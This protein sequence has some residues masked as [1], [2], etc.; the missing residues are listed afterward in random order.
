MTSPTTRTNFWG[1]VRWWWQGR[2]WRR[3]QF[4]V[5]AVLAAACI[6][7]I[8]GMCLNTT[9]QELES[10]YLSE[11]KSAFQAKDYARALT[12]YERIVPNA[13]DRPDTLYRLA[14][15]AE[16]M[17]DH[18]RTA[19]IMRELAPDDRKGYPPAHYWRARQYL[20]LSPSPRVISAAELHLLRAL[21]GELE[22]R[23]T[24][25]G[26]LGQIYLNN[27]RLDEAEFHLTKAVASNPDFRMNLA[28]LF[29]ARGNTAKARQEA[30]VAA[31]KFRD[32]AR[33]DPANITARLAWANAVTF[34]EDF[35][36]ALDILKDGI[37]AT[38]DPTIYH[39]FIA[40][41]Y[42]AWYD[43]RKKEAGV[44]ISELIT[45]ID[46]GLSH[47][48]TNKDLLN[49]LIEQLRYGGPGADQGRKVL[50]ELLAKGGTAMGPVHF[51]LAID[52]RVR[53]NGADEKFH[54]ERAYQL[55]P[56]SSLLAN[57]LA[58]V[59]SQ[60]PNSDFPRAL[61]LVDVA[62]E[63]EPNNPTYRDTRGMI[64][65]AMGRWKDALTDLEIVLAKAPGTTGLHSA[66][67]EVYDKLNQPALASEHRALAT[68]SARKKQ[69]P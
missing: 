65:K 28:W 39:F 56:K 36:A 8:A 29:Q 52:A 47:D 40:T 37:A 13:S 11:A 9:P 17:G 30:E 58:L 67:A 31:R 61:T 5:P 24:A 7:G 19:T 15:T 27:G 55:D 3:A 64:Y 62:I 16:A 41:V 68:E 66:L 1:Q 54:L 21:D 6:V 23:A 2:E 35:P 49:R 4:W 60:P 43:V 44:P 26:I 53:G 63:R 69:T 12:C 20:N 22:Q 32:L 10:R 45:L 48:L 33:A 25:H 59:L 18:A 42:R 46:K 50:L 57:N 34:L 51:A 14:L 38:N